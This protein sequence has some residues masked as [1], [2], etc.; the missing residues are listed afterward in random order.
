M[1]SA[2]VTISIAATSGLAEDTV[3][4]QFPFITDGSVGSAAPDLFDA[5]N[6]FYNDVDGAANN[7]AQFLSPHLGG[8]SPAACTARLYDITG[9]EDGSPHGSPV[10]QTTFGLAAREDPSTALPEEVALVLTTR[11]VN[12]AAQPIEAPDGSD[13]GSAIDRPRQ[14][15]T[16]RIFLGP[17]NDSALSEVDGKSRPILALRT[18]ILNKAEALHDEIAAA[19][20][21]WCVW[22]RSDEALR[23]IT[24]V[25][26]DDSWDTQRRRGVSPTARTTRTVNP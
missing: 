10:S 19:G 9:H 3:V 15:Y 22:S 8:T 24:D 16:G 23:S 26:V 12:W 25:Q 20:H 2:L 1:A 11:A 21:F 7:I 14:R 17:F 5:L 18:T 6:S 13:A 4:N